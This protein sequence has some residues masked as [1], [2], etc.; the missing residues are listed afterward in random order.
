MDNKENV[1]EEISTAGQENEEKSPLGKFKDVNAL[2][3]AY[4]SLQAEFTRR[5]QRLKQL[6]RAGKPSEGEALSCEEKK[7]LEV[8]SVAQEE[9][10]QGFDEQTEPMG[11][12]LNESTPV[13]PKLVEDTAG[14]GK[15]AVAAD[16]G[17]NRKDGE[18]QTLPSAEELYRM[19]SKDERVRLQI[20]GDYL[21]S[22]QTS[23]A[24]I[25]KGGLG[26]PVTPPKKARSIGD[27]GT[28]ALRMFLDANK[29][30]F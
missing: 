23:G 6:E 3:Q 8:T 9:G 27:A 20:V 30:Q 21:Q 24:P 29:T 7:G 15:D 2:M 16:S 18:V 12:G 5:S 19:A 13:A 10:R 17:E 4:N 11:Q 1:C 28:M 14:I 26:A 25:N 22:L